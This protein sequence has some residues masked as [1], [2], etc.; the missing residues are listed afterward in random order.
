MNLSKALCVAVLS[1]ALAQIP[2]SRNACGAMISTN[3]AVSSLMRTE[4]LAKVEE[5]IARGEVRGQFEKL[6]VDPAEATMRIASLNDFELGKLAGQI[7]QKPAGAD[8]VVISVTTVLLIVIILLL[9]H[10]I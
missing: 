10:K 9:L 4:N 6:G 3:E 8:V 7:E 1:I 2:F 5:F